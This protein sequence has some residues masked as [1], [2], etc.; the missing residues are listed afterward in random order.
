MHE[1]SAQQGD[2]DGEEATE[3]SE[4]YVRT[5]STENRQA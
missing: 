3:E 4:E 1:G 5:A 2:E